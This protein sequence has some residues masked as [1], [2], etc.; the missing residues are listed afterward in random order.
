MTKGETM[1]SNN[2]LKE[3]IFAGGCFWCNEAAFEAIEGVTEVISGYTGGEE[4]NPT[5]EQVLSG[6]TGHHEAV[7][8]IY[9]P[10]IISYKELVERF[11]RQI[12]PTD[13]E[14]Q[15]VDRG[16]QYTTAIFYQ[17]GEEKQI[18][19]QSKSELESS[20]RFD[21]PIATKI[22]SVMPFYPAEE[23]HQDFYKKK[24]LRYKAYRDGSGR[25]VL[26]EIWGE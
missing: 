5:Y 19:E 14:G 8:V 25:E 22:L 16:A 12:D 13:D 6:T 3:A 4:Q 2:N 7:K 20:G 10:E 23:Y 1:Q 11:W 9:D 17:N 26:D 24:T 21:K 18:A 15:F